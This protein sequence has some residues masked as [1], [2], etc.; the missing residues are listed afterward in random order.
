MQGCVRDLVPEV[1]LSA[2]PRDAPIV[3]G[4][5][6]TVMIAAETTRAAAIIFP[7][8]RAVELNVAHRTHLGTAA[9]VGA[10]VAVDSELLVCNHEAVEV[11]TNDVTERPGRQPQRQLTIARFSVQDNLLEC[12][13]LYPR[14]LQLPV[15]TF[16]GVGVHKGQTDVA[17]RHRQRLTALQRDALLLQFLGQHRHRQSCAVATGTERV[18]VVLGDGQRG[19]WGVQRHLTNELTYNGGCHP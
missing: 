4:V 1:I 15:F 16:G 10:D 19:L 2:P 5:N 12:L 3:D 9:T 14:P 17:L 18:G 11:S 13:Q 6:G 7:S 8:R